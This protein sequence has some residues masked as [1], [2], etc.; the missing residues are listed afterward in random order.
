M[1]TIREYLQELTRLNDGATKTITKILNKCEK[2]AKNGLDWC[3]VKVNNDELQETVEYLVEIAKLNVQVCHK[4]EHVS[5]LEIHW[6][7]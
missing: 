2:R 3:I 4:N 1:K 6:E 7:V 5:K